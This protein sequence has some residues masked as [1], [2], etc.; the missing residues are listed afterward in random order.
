MRALKVLEK[1]RFSGEEQLGINLIKRALEEPVR[2]I[3]QNAARV[4]W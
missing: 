1:A 2:Q 3:A 4:L